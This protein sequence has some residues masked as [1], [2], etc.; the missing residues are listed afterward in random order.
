MSA[1][2]P[3]AKD[4]YRTALVWKP[5]KHLSIHHHT[6]GS[7]PDGQV[8]GFPLAFPLRYATNPGERGAVYGTDT[9]LTTMQVLRNA[10]GGLSQTNVEDIFY[11][12]A[13]VGYFGRPA[14]VIM[15]HENA[16]GFARESKREPLV[17]LYQ[18]ARDYDFR[19][20][21][22]GVVGMNVPLDRDTA[23]ELRRTFV[24]V[25]AAPDVDE[26]VL[27]LLDA[28][29]SKSPSLRVVRYEQD[30]LRTLPRFSGHACEPVAKQLPDGTV[31]SAYPHLT[32]VREAVDLLSFVRTKA[33]PE[34]RALLDARDALYL[35]INVRS[36]SAVAVKNGTLVGVGTGQNSRV[37]TFEQLVAANRKL[38]ELS[39]TEPNFRSE[40][41]TDY[42]L[43]GAAVATDAFFPF[44]DA[45]LVGYEAGIRTFVSVQGSSREAEVIAALDQRGDAALILL[46]PE[47]RHFSHH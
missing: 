43:E 34:P 22:G 2:P 36:N 1:D 18:R 45:A 21:F 9:L 24:E 39:R 42:S 12:L 23:R 20:S 32:A 11:A 15:K 7:S 41:G 19:S 30:Y 47:E 5:E 10:K 38:Q 16:C 26:G 13:T 37:D 6:W 44:P 29:G 40:H 33:E 8:A 46:P 35:D 3:K 4:V 25:V 28:P 14:V 27:D 17:L 31:I